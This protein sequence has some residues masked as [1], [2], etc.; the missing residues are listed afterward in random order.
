MAKIFIESKPIF[1]FEHLYLVFQDNDGNEFVVRGGPERDNVFD[2]GNIIVE[3]GVAIEDSEDARVDDQGNAVTAESRGQKELDLGN[4]DAQDVWDIILQQV[5]N[6]GNAGL[7]YTLPPGAQNSNST[8]ASAL[9]SVGIDASN[10]LPGNV[11]DLDDIPGQENLLIVNGLLNGTLGNDT[12]IGFAGNDTLNGLAGNDVID[13]QGGND[14]L[15]GGTGDDAILG[16]TG[17]DTLD[18]GFDNDFL[19]GGEGND[20]IDGGEDSDR[21]S[22]STGNDTLIGGTGHDTAVYSGDNT[23]ARYEINNKS[24]D[25]T[26]IITDKL[27]VEGTDRLTGVEIG[28]FNVGEAVNNNSL[29]F[30]D[31]VVLQNNCLHA[32]I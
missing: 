18:G 4:R 28:E 8:I 25:G 7:D 3:V 26:V 30:S 16:D 27:G 10:V 31:L 13:G 12:L 6:I 5:T 32:M 17:N 21:L 29:Q 22:G 14:L 19:V 1:G 24:P 23:T 9:H 2:L 15:T 11:A 20:S